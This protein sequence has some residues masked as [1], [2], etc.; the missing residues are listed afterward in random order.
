MSIKVMLERVS[1]EGKL[2]RFGIKV[3]KG[4]NIKAKT[5]KVIWNKDNPIFNR[6]RRGVKYLR[7]GIFVSNDVLIKFVSNTLFPDCKF[8]GVIEL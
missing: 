5:I 8:I 7:A 1:D 4:G 3:K 2:E 6:G